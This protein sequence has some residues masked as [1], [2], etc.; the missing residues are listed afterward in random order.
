MALETND[1]QFTT[2]GVYQDAD[3]ISPG[4]QEGQRGVPIPRLPPKA[5]R[6][7]RKS[8]AERRGKDETRKKDRVGRKAKNAGQ[9][10]DP[11]DRKRRQMG[12][13]GRAR[14]RTDIQP[15]G[16]ARTAARAK[17]GGSPKA[18]RRQ[19]NRR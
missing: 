16:K 1:P 14:N 8:M 4:P 9:L 17:K 15:K 2:Q 19:G 7:A 3:D 6:R 13:T 11:M 18:K 10:R 12:P 5:R